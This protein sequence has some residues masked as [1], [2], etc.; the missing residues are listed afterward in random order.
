MIC[1]EK[2]SRKETKMPKFWIV[3]YTYRNRSGAFF[4]DMRTFEGREGAM[5]FFNDQVKLGGVSTAMLISCNDGVPSM[6]VRYE[7]VGF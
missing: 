5:A 4:T 3:T 2:I 6:D 1:S 7:R